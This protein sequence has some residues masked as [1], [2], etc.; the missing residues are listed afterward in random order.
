MAKGSKKRRHGKD[1]REEGGSHPEEAASGEAPAGSAAEAGAAVLEPEFAS[2]PAERLARLQAEF[3]NYR[4]RTERERL[5]TVSW[6]QAALVEK[7]LPV[8]DDLD[9]AAGSVEDHDAATT[10]G[11]LMVRDKLLRILAD[12]GLET[13]PAVGEPF[14]PNVHEALMTEPVEGERVGKVLEEFVTGYRYKG[15]VLRPSQVKV[16]MTAGGE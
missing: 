10:Q 11:F 5:E 8:V 13:I 12:A 14:D 1:P 3:D 9:R 16:G 15:R 6:A 2:V 7:L 4:K